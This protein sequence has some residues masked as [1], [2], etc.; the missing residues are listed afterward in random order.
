MARGG[1]DVVLSGEVAE[2]A[3]GRPRVSGIL[4]ACEGDK[5]TMEVVQKA[6]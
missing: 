3:S 6:A 5:K 4:L 2:L 1:E